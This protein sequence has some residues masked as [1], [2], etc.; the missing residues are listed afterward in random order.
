MSLSKVSRKV[1]N[2]KILL[3]SRTGFDLVLYID[4]MPYVIEIQSFELFDYFTSVGFYCN[5]IVTLVV[6]YAAEGMGICVDICRFIRDPIV[7]MKCL[8]QF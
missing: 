7:Y 6:H 4:F 5:R 8:L 3:R 1:K 2:S